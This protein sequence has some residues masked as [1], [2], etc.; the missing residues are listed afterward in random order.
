MLPFQKE[1]VQLGIFR[2]ER[3]SQAVFASGLV[4]PASCRI[5]GQTTSVAVHTYTID[6][7]QM[8]GFAPNILLM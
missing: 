7:R 5:D 4:G 3:F 6:N 2:E 8:D 1:C